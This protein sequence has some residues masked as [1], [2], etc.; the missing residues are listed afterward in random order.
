MTISHSNPRGLRPHSSRYRHLYSEP[1]EGPKI[2][3]TLPSAG[4]SLRYSGQ[5]EYLHPPQSQG[6]FPDSR[7]LRY[8]ILFHVAAEI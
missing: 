3:D 6:T 1:R 8:K 5:R 4:P 2:E 7:N